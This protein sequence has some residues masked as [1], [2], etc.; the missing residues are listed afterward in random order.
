MLPFGTKG[1]LT[2]RNSPRKHEDLI[3]AL[4]GAVQFLTQVALIHYRGHQRDGFF[5]NQGISKVDQM[6]KRAA[7]F[8]DPEQVMTIVL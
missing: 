5:V 8:Q 1:M 3:L 4:S 7:R 2:A 6:A